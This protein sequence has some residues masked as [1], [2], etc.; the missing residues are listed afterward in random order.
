M[1]GDKICLNGKI[2]EANELLTDINLLLSSNYIY[3]DILTIGYESYLLSHHI[4]IVKSFIYTSE[5]Q[6]NQA[7]SATLKEN[8]YPATRTVVRLYLFGSDWVIVPLKQLL[9]NHFTLWHTRVRATTIEYELSSPNPCGSTL[10]AHDN[11]QQIALGAGFDVA[12]REYNES[13]FGVGQY[14]LF[15]VKDRVCYTQPLHLGAENNVMR[16]WA[17][18][19]IIKSELSMKEEHIDVKEEF[20]E[21]FFATPQGITSIRSLDHRPLYSSVATIL[22]S[23]MALL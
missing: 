13:L 12:I 5:Y 7:I 19:L 17:E 2:V 4:D 10:M 16:K 18:E 9:Y 6:L 8:N 15:C 11:A 23:T 14:P 20:S 1:S 3:Q 21:M 22:E